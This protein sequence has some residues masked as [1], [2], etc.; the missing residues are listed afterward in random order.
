MRVR[1]S[2]LPSG[3]SSSSRPGIVDQGPG[4]RHALRHAAG[5]LVRIGVG[6]V[7]Q[8]DQRRAPRRRGGPG[9]AAG[10]APPGP[11]RRWPGPV[12]HGYSVGSWNMTT[13]RRIG[14]GDLA[15][16][17]REACRRSAAPARRPAA[18]GWTCR[19]RE[20]PS[21][22]TN[23]PGSMRRSTRS[24]TGSGLPSRSKAWLTS[25]DVEARAARAPG[26]RAASGYHW[27]SPFC[28]ASSRSRRRNS[29]VIRPGTSA[30]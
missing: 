15:A 16:V 19:S 20:G 11:A 13:R 14:A 9:C 23:S 4:Q 26:R 21:R 12:R 29:R 24:S 1:Q 6:E 8:A 22:A 18:A 17:G 2:S 25:A 7:A 27:T 10:R 5:E 30:P 28:Q 3:S